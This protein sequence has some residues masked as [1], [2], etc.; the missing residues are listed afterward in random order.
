E[1]VDAHPRQENNCGENDSCHRIAGP[2]SPIPRISTMQIVDTHCG[3]DA[4]DRIDQE[5]A[6]CA[7]TLLDD[8]AEGIERQHVEKQVS[9]VRMSEVRKKHA[10]IVP[11][12]GNL[13][14]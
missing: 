8:G 9:A 5:H 14:R 4:R 12:C 3:E 13:A 11:A 1:E 7:Q 6:Q 10:L 2:E